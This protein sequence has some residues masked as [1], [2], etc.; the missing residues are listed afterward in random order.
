MGKNYEYKSQIL[1]WGVQ[2]G[3]N[4]ITVENYE[5]WRR[6]ANN[7]E[8]D[9]RKIANL[10]YGRLYRRYIKPFEF[11]DSIYKKEYKNGFAIMANCCLLI[12]T[13]ESFYRNWPNTKNKSEF[14]FLK[15]FSRDVRF[16]K[17][18]TDDMPTLFYK[19]IRCGILHQ[20][21]ST[22]GWRISR[23]LEDPILDKKRRL[24]QTVRFQKALK[25]SLNDYKSELEKTDWKSDIWQNCKKK[26]NSVIENC[27]IS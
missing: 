14:A 26:M 16:K 12:E 17:F 18:S 24:I 1:L 5:E 2:Q 11:E 8:E 15:F 27:K 25:K 3:E 9:K 19:H 23:K 10:V 4:H 7:N 20:G 13:L 21:E 22:G 6:T